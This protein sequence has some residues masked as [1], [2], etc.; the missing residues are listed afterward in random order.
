MAF[1]VKCSSSIKCH[2]IPI[3]T[4]EL[5]NKWPLPVLGLGVVAGSVTTTSC[6]SATTFSC[7]KG[8]QAPTN[9]FTAHACTPPPPHL[10]LLP[11]VGVGDEGSLGSQMAESLPVIKQINDEFRDPVSPRV[12]M[13]TCTYMYMYM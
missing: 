2:H 4:C 13:Y 7:P 3:V 12:D 1:L 11:A 10:Q 8:N 6:L 9:C 5:Y